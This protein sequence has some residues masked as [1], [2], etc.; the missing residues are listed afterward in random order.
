M[1]GRRCLW[2]VEISKIEGLGLFKPLWQIVVASGGSKHSKI[3]LDFLS[4]YSGPALPPA[5]P[6]AQQLKTLDFF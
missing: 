2:R 5:G 1:A 4:L 6:N 3:E